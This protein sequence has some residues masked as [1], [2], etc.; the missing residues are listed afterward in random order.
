MVLDNF[1]SVACL[2]ILPIVFIP[3]SITFM[4]RGRNTRNTSTDR[5]VTQTLIGHYNTERESHVMQPCNRRKP[6]LTDSQ[7]FQPSLHLQ[8]RSFNWFRYLKVRKEM[9]LQDT[10]WNLSSG[11]QTGRSSRSYVVYSLGASIYDISIDQNHVSRLRALVVWWTCISGI[12]S[13]MRVVWLSSTA[14]SNGSDGHRRRNILRR[15]GLR[16][17]LEKGANSP[18]LASSR[19]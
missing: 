2:K 5:Y 15:N 9:L 18:S 7:Y 14:I 3:F 12:I 13:L 19:N 10:S 6:S 1:I 16:L 4:I 8:D 11:K 17:V